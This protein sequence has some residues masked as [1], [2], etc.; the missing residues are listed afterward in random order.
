MPLAFSRP[1]DRLLTSHPLPSGGPLKRWYQFLAR[2][3]ATKAEKAANNERLHAKCLLFTI[4]MQHGIGCTG[5]LCILPL[6]PWSK[7]WV[8]FGTL[9]S[10]SLALY[11]ASLIHMVV[12]KRQWLSW[13][14][15]GIS[16]TAGTSSPSR[17]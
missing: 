15:S 6:I 11:L 2:Y 5:G 13:I 9:C 8:V 16:F 3:I 1:A 12:T 10:L 4:N 14:A 17:S 7:A